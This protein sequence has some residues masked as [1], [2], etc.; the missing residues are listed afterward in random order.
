[1]DIERCAPNPKVTASAY[2]S[3][4]LKPAEAAQFEDHFIGCPR[5]GDSL[6]F[7]KHFVI[8]VQHS[9]ERLKNGS[10]SRQ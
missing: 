7:T 8:A 4:A 10:I 6:Q 1:M 2:L 3:G 9:A 5:C